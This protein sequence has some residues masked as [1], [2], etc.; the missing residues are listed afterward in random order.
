MISIE[1]PGT[2][3]GEGPGVGSHERARHGKRSLGLVA[4]EEP[5]TGWGEGPGVCSYRTG[6]LLHREN[7]ENGNNKNRQNTGN[8]EILPKHREFGLLKL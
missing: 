6:Y 8:L 7:R 5:G 3:W 1:E 4:I 2:G